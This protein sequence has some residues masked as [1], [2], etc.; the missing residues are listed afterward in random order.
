VAEKSK[1]PRISHIGLM[2]QILISF[3]FLSHQA[4]TGCSD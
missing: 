2:F 4:Y 3:V 1:P